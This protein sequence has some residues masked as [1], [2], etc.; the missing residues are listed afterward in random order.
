MKN[1]SLVL[2]S[3]LLVFIFSTSKLTAQS[4]PVVKKAEL[5]KQKPAQKYYAITVKKH[6]NKVLKKAANPKKG[7]KL[8]LADEKLTKVKNK[9]NIAKQNHSKVKPKK[10]PIKRRR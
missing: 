2:L 5:I 7:K 10:T 6:N 4:L 8:G 9:K 1:L 3:T